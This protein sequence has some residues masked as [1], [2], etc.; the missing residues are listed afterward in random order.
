MATKL[1]KL[2]IEISGDCR[3]TQNAYGFTM[4]IHED[5]TKPTNPMTWIPKSRS[6]DFCE[7][8]GFVTFW[9]EDWLV[10]EKALE[11]FI[12]TSYLPSLFE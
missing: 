3:E 11:D 8:E 5:F 1:N 6:S 2:K 12:D 10:I 7:S 9:M 4:K